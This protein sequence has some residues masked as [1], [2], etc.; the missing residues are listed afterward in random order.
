MD[1]NY[2]DCTPLKELL[3]YLQVFFL[4]VTFGIFH[5]LVFLPVLLSLVGPSPYKLKKDGLKSETETEKDA[6]TKF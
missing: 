3:S 2:F 6:T 5:G 1:L 4:V